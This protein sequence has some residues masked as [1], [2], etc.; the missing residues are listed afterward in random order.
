M[1]KKSTALV[2]NTA[3]SQLGAATPVRTATDQVVALSKVLGS[4]AT[5]L[6][7][8]S[9]K[10]EEIEVAGKTVVAVRELID[11]AEK[12][13]KALTQPLVDEKKAI[14]DVYKSFKARAGAIDTHLGSLLLV[15]DAQRRATLAKAAEKDAKKLEKAGATQA[16]EDLRES[17]AK[18]PAVFAGSG[19]TTTT[20]KKVVVNDMKALCAAIAKGDVPSTLVEP[21][22]S[23]LNA[24]LK[25]GAELPP[26]CS[27]V[28]ESTIKRT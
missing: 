10:E 3:G 12:G 18:A 5:W 24:L 4:Y 16:A 20:T 27:V 2:R 28:E 19:I 25:V 15:A 23:A 8:K 13:R 1:A 26:G 9:L 17:V 21:V 7:K 22:Q 11:T 14:D 6:E